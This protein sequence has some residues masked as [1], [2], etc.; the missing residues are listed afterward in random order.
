MALSDQTTQ[1]DENGE[2]IP[3]LVDVDSDTDDEEHYIKAATNPVTLVDSP[4]VFKGLHAML[5]R[6]R[7]APATIDLSSHIDSSSVINPPV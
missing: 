3:L 1:Y 7:V 2:E 5:D 4:D 6:L